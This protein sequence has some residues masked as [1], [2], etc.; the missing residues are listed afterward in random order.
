MLGAALFSYLAFF[1]LVF[2][3]G[4]WDIG[5]GYYFACVPLLVPLFVRGIAALRRLAP[6]VP[7]RA[8]GW[9]VI[10][11]AVTAWTTIAPRHALHLA[12]LAREIRAPWEAVE[13]SGIGEANVVV[14][15][16]SRR[17]AAGWGFGYPYTIATSATTRAHLLQPLTRAEYDAAIRYL[18]QRPVYTLVPHGQSFQ[19]SG[20]RAFEIVPFNPD[21]YFASAGDT[22]R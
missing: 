3:S 1:M 17:L 7:A 4:V 12:I 20:R 6:G 15:D 11:G 9:L 21:E 22:Q 19:R 8:A 10:V 5:P 16:I 2:G 18:G 13:E 14:P